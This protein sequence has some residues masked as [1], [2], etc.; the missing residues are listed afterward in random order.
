M[1]LLFVRLMLHPAKNKDAALERLIPHVHTP[2]SSLI[3]FNITDYKSFFVC[4]ELAKGCSFPCDYIFGISIPPGQPF[5]GLKSQMFRYQQI[6][7]E[8]VESGIR[9][10]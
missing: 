3:L 5:C 10:H 4:F 7:R 9:L 6:H 2:T 1:F 8:G